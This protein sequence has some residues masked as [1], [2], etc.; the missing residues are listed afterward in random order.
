M[1]GGAGTPESHTFSAL[2]EDTDYYFGI[3]V[4]DGNGG[5]STLSVLPVTK[6]LD[7]TA[8]E[9]A[10]NFSVG[11]GVVPQQASVT[12][13]DVSGEINAK[14]LKEEVVDGDTLSF[15]SS[16]ARAVAQEEFLILD[17]SSARTVKGLRLRSRHVSGALFP[18]D[19]VIETGLVNSNAG[20]VAQVAVTGFT[21]APATWYDFTFSSPVSA[22]FIRLKITKSRQYFGNFYA[23]L[24]ELI[25]DEEIVES[26]KIS[27]NWDAP[28]E[29]GSLGGAATQYHIMV[30]T[31][32]IL[33]ATPTSTLAGLPTPA[34]PDVSQSFLIQ[35]LDP[36]TTYYIVLW[37]EDEAGNFSPGAS[38][39]STTG[40]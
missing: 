14:R 29:N 9:E 20:L 27:V 10:P 30:D 22:R 31:N 38:G 7:G 33:E 8:P 34:A 26:D 19:F 23:Q 40:P 1:T 24:S 37:S 11:Q 35:G 3:R 2:T 39:S 21:A 6:T 32:P 15:W 18:E 12:V 25:V 16:P 17:L 4:D 36:A 13:I 5:L 28:N